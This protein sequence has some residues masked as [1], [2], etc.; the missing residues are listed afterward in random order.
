ML[1]YESRYLHEIFSIW[2]SYECATCDK[3]I[4]AVSQS[5]CQPQPISAKTLDASSNLICW[6]ISKRKKT[7]EVLDLYESPEGRN[8]QYLQK[9][10]VLN[11]FA[12]PRRPPSRR[13]R[14][15]PPVQ[16]SELKMN[17][18][19][20]FSSTIDLLENYKIFQYFSLIIF[21]VLTK[22]SPCLHEVSIIQQEHM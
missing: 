15:M 11:F 17:L 2:S 3:K 10:G 14:I 4:W 19:N 18:I 6:D 12:E 5:A 7:G 20:G 1:K 9:N 21:M 13:P 8:F 22:L 16:K